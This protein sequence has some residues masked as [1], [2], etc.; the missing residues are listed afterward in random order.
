M[1]KK[2]VPKMVKKDLR[3]EEHPV[4]LYP[5][6]ERRKHRNCQSRLSTVCAACTMMIVDRTKHHGSSCTK[7]K[8]G[9]G[10]W[11]GGKGWNRLAQ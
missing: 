8:C 1:V 3:M 7:S 6:P 11:I 2:P 9:E 10:F 4:E 5:A